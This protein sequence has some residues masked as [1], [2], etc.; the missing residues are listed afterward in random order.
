MGNI[1]PNLPSLVTPLV[2]TLE[3]RNARVSPCYAKQREQRK[4]IIEVRV[5]AP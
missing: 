3:V 1:N 4:Q 2:E 5:E